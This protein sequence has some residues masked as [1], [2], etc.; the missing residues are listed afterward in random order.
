MAEQRP[1]GGVTYLFADETERIALESRYNGLIDVQ[2]ETLDSLK[3]G[4]IVFGTD[5][6]LKLFN[7]AFCEIWHMLPRKLEELP[8][9][10]EIIATAQALHPDN[11][12]WVRIGR[13]VTA[14]LEEREGFSGQMNRADGLVIDYALMPLPDGATLLTFANVTDAKLAERALVERNEALVAADRLKT[15]FIGHISYELRTPLQTIIGFADLLASPAFGEI[16]DKQREYLTDI[17]SSSQTLLSLINDIIDL[18]T[19]DAGSLQLKPAPVGVRALIDAAIV[20][21]RERAIRSRLTIEIAVADDV[22]EFMADEGR[23][24]QVLYNLLSNA[25]G[26]SSNESTVRLSCWRERGDIVFTVED[27]GPGIP[28]DQLGGVFGRF[29]SRSRGSQHRGAGLGLSIAK[30]LIELHGGTIAIA[31]EEGRGTR[32]TV[33]IPE[34]PLISGDSIRPLAQGGRAA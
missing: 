13:A 30:S 17:M 10:G 16:N 11:E 22:N 24:R 33:H 25:I 6:R 21:I 8:H 18:T 26:F 12:T 31:S 9:V 19:I 27:E 23:M 28:H 7:R 3:E 14:F 5:G 2:R 4:V 20:G 34:R 1:D 32:V 15:N 29:E